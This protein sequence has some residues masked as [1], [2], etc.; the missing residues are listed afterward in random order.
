MA[1]LSGNELPEIAQPVLQLAPGIAASIVA[2]AL[3]GY[4]DEVCGLLSGRGETVMR[5][6]RGRNVAAK[7]GVAF[8]LD[9]DTLAL[10]LR[11]EDE[12]L[13]LVA[14]YHSHPH[15]AAL[16]SET[17]ISRHYYPNAVALICSLLDCNRPELRGY[18]IVDRTVIP[19]A[20]RTLASQG[21]ASPCD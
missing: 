20:L 12:G 18:R 9:A 10:Q 4:P 15:T 21:P 2:H 14:I 3:E 7:P 13:G 8:E 19:V 1:P 11:F 6:H 16:P 17:D 5:L